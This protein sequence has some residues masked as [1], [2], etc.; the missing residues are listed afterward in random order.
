VISHEWG[1]ER[2]V[3]TTSGTYPWSFVTQIFHSGQPDH[4]GDRK[5]F[6]VMTSTW[7]RRSLGPVASL[8]AVIIYQG[9]PDRNHKLWNIVSTERYILHMHIPYCNIIYQYRT[10]NNCVL[11]CVRRVFDI[12]YVLLVLVLCLLYPMLSVSRDCQFLIAL[13]VFFDIILL[14]FRFPNYIFSTI[15]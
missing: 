12:L 14:A 7:P 4:G 13:S 8:L 9:N 10:A 2:E 15:V 6:E 3:L 11:C 1:K 5:T